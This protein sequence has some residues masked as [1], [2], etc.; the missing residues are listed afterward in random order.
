MPAQ[1][2]YP[3]AARALGLPEGPASRNPAGRPSRKNAPRKLSGG[4]APG[5][6]EWHRHLLTGTILRCVTLGGLWPANRSH[7]RYR[8]I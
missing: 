2:L 1:A 6:T 3:I 8:P 5:P 4:V 7:P